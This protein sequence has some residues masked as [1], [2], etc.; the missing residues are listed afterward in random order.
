VVK[1]ELE[2]ENM[3][4]GNRTGKLALGFPKRQVRNENINPKR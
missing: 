2:R 3:K 4:K 1:V